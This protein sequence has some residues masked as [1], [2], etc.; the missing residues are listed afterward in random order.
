MQTLQNLSGS[1]K[2]ATTLDKLD[3][4][5]DRVERQI[6]RVE[7]RLEDLIKRKN[8]Y[9]KRIFEMQI[10]AIE[11]KQKRCKHI[12]ITDYTYCQRDDCSGRHRHCK[13]CGLE[14]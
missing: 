3:K 8:L 7:R 14:I 4:E 2:M 1:G 13:D 12:N 11:R 5:I 9:A 6:D 10:K